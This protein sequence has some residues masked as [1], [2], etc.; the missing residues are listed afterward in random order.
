MLESSELEFIMEAHNG[1]SAK[2]V[3]EAGRDKNQ[4]QSYLLDFLLLTHEWSNLLVKHIWLSGFS[5]HIF[6]LTSNLV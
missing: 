2:I 5:K 3:Q 6:C 4:V 1:L